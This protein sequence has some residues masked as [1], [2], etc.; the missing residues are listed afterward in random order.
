MLKLDLSERRERVLDY[1][2]DDSI[3]IIFSGENVKSEDG[4][5]YE[6]QV[7]REFYYLTGVDQADSILLL[8]KVNSMKRA[9]LFIPKNN[10]RSFKWTGV[11]PSIPETMT[12][13]GIEDVAYL[14]EFEDYINDFANSEDLKSIYVCIENSDDE[15]LSI[16]GRMFEELYEFFDRVQFRNVKNFISSLREVKSLNEVENIINAI[17]NTKVALTLAMKNAKADIMEAELSALIDYVSRRRCDGVAFPTIVAAGKNAT[18]LHYQKGMNT[19]KDGQMVLIDCGS[20]VDKYNSDISR[21]FPVNGRFSEIQKQ[22]Y[23]I[24]LKANK[25]VI[26]MIKPGVTIR[27]LN[28]RVI[29]IYENELKENG[30]IEDRSQIADVYYHNVSHGLGLSTHDPFD[31]DAPLKEGNVITVEPGLYF[32]EYELGVRIEDDVLVTGDGHLNLSEDIIKEIDEIE[33][34][35]NQA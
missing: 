13:S 22:I 16:N 32:E 2:I 21:T 33:E 28:D 3:G 5:E 27:E 15:D 23:S 24:V 17:R 34:L 30:L 29:D 31:M 4:N 6:F 25:E 11:R 14:E 35:M 10:E 12:K 26:D 18:T 9:I 20:S 19:L 7:N 8:C 1:M